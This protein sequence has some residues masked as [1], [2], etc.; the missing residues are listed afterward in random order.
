MSNERRIDLS[1]LHRSTKN[2]KSIEKPAITKAP[3]VQQNIQPVMQPIAQPSLSNQFIEELLRTTPSNDFS[4]QMVTSLEK[5]KEDDK[6]DRRRQILILQ[7]YINE[8]PEKLKAF[9][10]TNFEKMSD[11]ELKAT[12]S[13]FDF[14][15]SS[16]T[17]IGT[18]QYAFIQGIHLLENV[19]VTLTPLKIQGLANMVDDQD[20]RDDVKALCL[21][22]M[23]FI[24]T[25]P[26]QRIAF[27]LLSSALLLHQINSNNPNIINKSAKLSEINNKY[28]DL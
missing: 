6:I 14:I 8:F 26:E 22:H 3:P 28:T 1:K 16:K 19:C 15:I 25:E 11:D 7:L 9:K 27:K 18:T 23:G 17:N 21:K 2:V 24:K 13:E 12:K 20:Y 10:S 4:K 5:P